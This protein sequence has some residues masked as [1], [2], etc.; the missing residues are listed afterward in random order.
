MSTRAKT[1]PLSQTEIID[2]SFMEYRNRL[3][4]LAAFLDRLDRARERDALGEAR[5]EALL[6]AMEEL[7]SDQ[8]GRVERVQMI[9]SDTNCALLDERDRQN[10]LGAAK[11]AAE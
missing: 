4:D 1:C 2:R 10:A 9:L 8:P 7:T 5:Y 3:L 11:P 6:D